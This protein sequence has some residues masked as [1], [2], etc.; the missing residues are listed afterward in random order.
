MCCVARLN[1]VVLFILIV[2]F[3]DCLMLVFVFLF[4]VYVLSLVCRVLYCVCVRDALGLR[5]CE[6]CGELYCVVVVLC[7]VCLC[8]I[9]LYCVVSYLVGWYCRGLFGVCCFVL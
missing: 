3:M 5:C 9:V 6:V 7:C 2:C 1:S 8:C 4:V